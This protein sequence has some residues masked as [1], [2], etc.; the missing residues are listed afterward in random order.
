MAGN[1]SGVR[2]DAAGAMAAAEL[3]IGNKYRRVRS[4]YAYTLA[5]AQLATRRLQAGS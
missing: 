2:G 4:W 1:A 5:S 3:R